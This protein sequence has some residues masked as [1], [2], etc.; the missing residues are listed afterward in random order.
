MD[1]IFKWY[2][3][4]DKKLKVNKVGDVV[5][6]TSP[7]FDNI[8]WLK[9]GFSTRL[10][11]VSGGVCESMNFAYND[12]D[13]VDNVARNHN[14]FCDA[15]GININK[16]VKTKQVHSNKVLKIDENHVFRK[17]D[18]PGWDYESY[19][20]LITNLNGTTLFAFSADCALI[21]IVDP[22]NKAIG[23]CHSGWRGTA[24][25]ISQVTINMMHENYGSNPDDLLVTIWPSICPECFEVEFDMISEARNSFNPSDWSDIYYQKSEVKY[26]FN[27]WEANKKVLQE[28]NI[29]T[30]HI[31]MPNLC[32]K[33]N[34]ST[35]FSHRNMGLKRGTLISYISICDN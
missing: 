12:H 30:A 34:P 3:D 7:L 16:I 29:P 28:A 23:S 9:A 32:T 17:S 35:L 13:L 14:I 27:L 4:N 26:Q 18:E 10:G 5:Y 21:T 25:K 31:Q 24:Q 33:C 22:V 19:D 8:P 15:T 1:S 6:L 11:G 2:N 20:G